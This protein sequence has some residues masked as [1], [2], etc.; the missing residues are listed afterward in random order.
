MDPGLYGCIAALV[1]VLYRHGIPV[2]HHVAR[3]RRLGPR[4]RRLLAITRLGVACLGVAVAAV[5][6]A[7]AAAP[8]LP[9]VEVEVAVLYLAGVG[10]ALGLLVWVE[11]SVVQ[12]RLA[13]EREAARAVARRE[14]AR[15][16]RTMLRL[17]LGPRSEQLL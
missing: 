6:I 12:L 4:Y 10:S 16:V 11:A 5:A 9:R 17:G 15:S 2:P 1:W 8:L 13:V 3:H 14:R 7:K